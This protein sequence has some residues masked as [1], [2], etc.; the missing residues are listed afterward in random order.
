MTFFQISLMKL[1]SGKSYLTMNNYVPFLKLKVNEIGALNALSPDIKNSIMPF[2]DLPRK[3]DMTPVSFQA[4]VNKT[5]ASITKNLNGID[6]F[7]LDN[8]DIE[9]GILVGG[10]NN[11]GYVI[12]SFSDMTFIPVVGLD[13]TLERNNLV[14]EHKKNGNIKSNAIAIRLSAEDFDSFAIVQT[15]IEELVAQGQD[16]FDKWILILDNRL[17]LNIDPAKRALLI[18][19]FLADA[20]GSFDPEM[21]IVAGSSV[22][23]SIGDVAAAGTEITHDR[24]ELSIYR[25][26]VKSVDDVNLWLGDYTIVSPLYSDLDIPPEAMQN[27]IAAKIIYSH[28]NV[29]YVARG[30]SLKS[31]PRGRMQY[32]DIANALIAKPFFRGAPYSFG[33]AY[34]DDKAHNIGSGVTPSSILKPTI[35][36]HMS[37]M[38][39]DFTA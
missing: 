8:F 16:L 33:D 22:P 29:H 24:V 13:R 15:E 31:H 19:V 38:I 34:L 10:Q 39:K 27:V 26:V 2:F 12:E 35:N 3:N 11:Y 32:N 4:M 25:A 7:F 6:V 20:K 18:S 37:W 9:D 30:G 17:C 21:V 5:V 23:P 1:M 36:T 28:D 14:F